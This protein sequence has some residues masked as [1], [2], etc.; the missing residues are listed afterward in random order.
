VSDA[1]E[2]RGRID[3]RKT[4]RRRL[5]A[6]QDILPW[7]TR[8]VSISPFGPG[9]W[10]FNPCVHR[11]QSGTWRVA[12]RLAN[13][14]LPGGIPQLSPDARQ[15]RAATRNVLATLDPVTLALASW[16]EVAELDDQPRAT[17]CASLGYEDLRLFST[18]RD[19]LM[20]IATALQ[21]N[22]QHPSRPEMVLL[23]FDEAGDVADARPLR[24]PWSAQAQKNWSPF[25]GA[26]EPRFLYSIERGVVMG[27]D[28]PVPGSPLPMSAEPR[29]LTGIVANNIGRCGVEVKVMGTMARAPGPVPA[30]PAPPGSTELRGGSQLVRVGGDRWLGIAHETKLMQPERKKFYWHTFYLLDD[31]G[32]MVERS[33]PFKLDGER[34]IEFAA[35]LAL[36]DQGGAAISY[37]TDDHDAW[38]AVTRLDA[39]LEILRP[40]GRADD[41]DG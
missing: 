14:S 38:I 17:S 24:G 32:R 40:I 35:G 7:M 39:I 9:W 10:S 8:C 4:G 37:G 6:A 36:D 29:Q 30:Q 27:E 23:R 15:G 1:L 20:G 16:R 13:Y 19:G 34:G 33:R 12:L 22:L 25:D 21:L 41:R 18:E 3:D 31:D 26:P 28:G 11:D 2:A 5:P